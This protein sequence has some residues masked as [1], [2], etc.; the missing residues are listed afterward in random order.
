MPRG[1]EIELKVDTSQADA[2]IER[3]ERRRRATEAAVK[4]TEQAAELT[5]YKVM[6]MLSIGRQVLSTYLEAFFGSLTA[7]QRAAIDSAFSMATLF[8]YEATAAGATGNFALATAF[9]LASVALSMQTAKL[10]E[11]QETRLQREMNNVSR[12]LSS[13]ATYTRIG[14]IG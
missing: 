8:T 13:L 7:T 1:V 9:M 10:Q 6:A 12:L 5:S 14:Y 4:Q 2:A 3:V 11:E